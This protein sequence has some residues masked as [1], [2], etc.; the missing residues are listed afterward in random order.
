MAERKKA[1]VTQDLKKKELIHLE[2][3]ASSNAVP[4]APD[5]L[6]AQK[7]PRAQPVWPINIDQT[8][9]GA[10]NRPGQKEA[11]AGVSPMDSSKQPNIFVEHGTMK[12]RKH[13]RDRHDEPV[14]CLTYK[15]PFA[16]VYKK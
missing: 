14:Q 13:G 6:D 9:D 2:V 11:A 4:L 15:D 5:N 3:A 16:S 10:I 1:K 8:K 7:P 12:P